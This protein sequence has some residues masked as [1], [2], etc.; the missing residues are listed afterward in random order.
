MAPSNSRCGA[1]S[2]TTGESLASP[3]QPLGPGELARIRRVGQHLLRRNSSVTT[4]VAAVG[5]NVEHV[6]QVRWWEDSEFS[7]SQ[8]LVAAELVAFDVLDPA[9]RSRGAVQEQARRLYDDDSFRERLRR[10]FTAEPSSCLILPTLADALEQIADLE[11]RLS[12]V[13]AK[14][15]DNPTGR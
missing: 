10:L 12:V 13:E 14:L 5:L 4:G 3:G 9:L 7:Q 8:V 11:R 2:T 1:C 15:A 6:T